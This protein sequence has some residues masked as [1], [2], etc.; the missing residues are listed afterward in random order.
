MNL[1][2][3]F[4]GGTFQFNVGPEAKAFVLHTKLVSQHS[5]VF[6]ALMCGNMREAEEK[7]TSLTGV[8][9]GTF[10]R[11]AE[12]IY[13][14]DYNVAEPLIVLD[15]W[16]TERDN[17]GSDSP[18]PVEAAPA[19][20]T[21]ET[22]E[23]PAVPPPQDE[24][25]DAHDWTLRHDSKKKRKREIQIPIRRRLSPF[26]RHSLPLI[27]KVSFPKIND[28]EAKSDTEL[29]YDYAETLCHVRLYIFA[30][31]YQVDALKDLAI[32]KLHGALKDTIF[33]PLR[34]G[35]LVDLIQL[36]YQN[37]PDLKSKKEPLRNLLAH[38]VA[39]KFEKLVPTKEFQPL[40]LAGGAFVNDLCEKVS[41]RL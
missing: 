39:W 16:E 31:Q 27:D 9:E 14:G 37:T 20:E 30:E 21:S 5:P 23:T 10:A 22:S 32:C 24:V 13:G 18:Q 7:Q 41:R 17:P 34:L 12:F 36:A 29:M 25:P 15:N 3:V 11:F 2:R 35:E 33:H 38:Y 40:L 8:D 26:A 1:S 19:E 4:V 28:P 6:H